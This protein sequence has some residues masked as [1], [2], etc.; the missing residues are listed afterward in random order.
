M[1]KGESAKKKKIVKRGDGRTRA[2]EA[3]TTQF[4]YHCRLIGRLYS[5]GDELKCYDRNY[6][7]ATK[8]PNCFAVNVGSVFFFIACAFMCFIGFALAICS[9]FQHRRQAIKRELE[10]HLDAGERLEAQPLYREQ[11]QNAQPLI[12]RK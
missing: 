11:N 4:C 9:F 2:D 1:C 6:S 7:K 8:Y 10:A 5:K 3:S 12:E